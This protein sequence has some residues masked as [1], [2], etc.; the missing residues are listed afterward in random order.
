MCE[1]GLLN[2]PEAHESANPVASAKTIMRPRHVS[3]ARRN[4][5][6]SV[7]A[8]LDWARARTRAFV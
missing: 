7:A 4:D 2:P 6:R 3:A 1:G 8:G 5:D